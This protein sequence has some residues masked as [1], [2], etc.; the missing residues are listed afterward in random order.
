MSILLVGGEK[1]GTGKTTIATNLAAMR[2][3][4]GRDVVLVDTDIQ[5]SA[6]LWC[7]VRDQGGIQPRIACVQLRGKAIATQLRDTASRYEDV[8]VDA[9]GRDS[10]ELRAA[11]T[12]ADSLLIPIQASQ[13]DTWTLESMAELVNQ[14]RGINPDLVAYVCV[15][16]A[17]SNPRVG[18]LDEAGKLLD[19]YEA[20]KMLETA[21]RDRIAF[22][23]A[24][25]SGQSVAEADSDDKAA[26]EVSA[27]HREVYA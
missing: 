26:R 21:L 10:V 2:A 22:R 16:R 7:S 11:M 19:E 9:G 3:K 17:S 14:A 24:A 6:S 13:F 20:F 8:I 23:H 12:V 27:L 15:N 25:R 5:A 1:G 4:A 18:E